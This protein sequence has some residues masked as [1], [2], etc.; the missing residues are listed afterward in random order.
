MVRDRTQ[1]GDAQHHQAGQA[2]LLIGRCNKATP[3]VTN[4]TAP[5]TGLVTAARKSRDVCEGLWRS[6]G[7]DLMTPLSIRASPIMAS[8]RAH[9][10]GRRSLRLVSG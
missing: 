8:V 10:T 3:A 5:V 7:R 6:S 1:D 2:Q 4:M 9:E